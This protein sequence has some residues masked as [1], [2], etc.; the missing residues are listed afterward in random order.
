MARSRTIIVSVGAFKKAVSASA[1][2]D[3][4]ILNPGVYKEGT[5][6]LTKPLTILG[7]GNVILDGENNYE[8]VTISGYHITIKN[9]QFRNAGYSAL[10]DFAAI[11]I[12]DASAVLL[13]SNTVTN[14]YFAIHVSNSSY[15]TIRNNVVTGSPKSEQLT[16]NGIHLWKCNRALIENNHVQGHRDGIYFEFVTGSVIRNNLSE[17]NIRYGLHFM[18]SNDDQYR[19]NTFRNNGAGVAVM[20]SKKVIMERNQFEQNW[21]PAA[22]GVLLKDI[23]DSYIHNNIFLK[24]TVGLHLEGTSR[25]RIEKNT[26]QSN[27]WAVKIQASCEDNDFFYNNFL[28]NSFDVGTNGTMVLNKF[29]KNYWDKYE[30]YDINKDGIGDVPYHPV[31]MYS[32]IVEENPH[33]LMLFRSFAVQLLDKAEKAIPGLTPEK[34]ADNKPM[35]KSLNL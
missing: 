21:G 35:M 17:K 27:G 34:L 2:G 8:I 25:M 11:K 23:S 28:G 6:L 30:G 12:I 20:Y 1:A 33:T 9:I 4:I 3:T 14:A 31:S 22:Y 13:E 26:F 24:N 19:Q 10:N 7:K 18:F 15:V 29:D 32:L 16:G 5:I